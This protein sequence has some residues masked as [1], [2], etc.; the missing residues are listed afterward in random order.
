MHVE[1]PGKPMSLTSISPGGFFC[2]SSSKGPISY[3]MRVVRKIPGKDQFVGSLILS[4]QS[5]R[6]DS[7]HIIKDCVN[8]TLTCAI[9]I[10]TAQLIPSL[11]SE[12]IRIC[13]T[14]IKPGCIVLNGGPT[15]LLAAKDGE[16]RI[17]YVNLS[18]GEIIHL[19][20]QDTTVISMWKVLVK[21][22]YGIVELCDFAYN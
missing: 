15:F 3:G 20:K 21:T 7:P 11:S 18:S 19:R 8:K 12:N 14:D 5:N 6:S 9:Y 4:S 22:S 17:G 2:L 10:P 13:A 16:A 1:F